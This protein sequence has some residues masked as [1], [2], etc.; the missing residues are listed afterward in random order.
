MRSLPFDSFAP[1]VGVPLMVASP[2]HDD[3]DALRD[4]CGQWQWGLYRARSCHAA[5]RLVRQRR[6]SVVLCDRDL[7]GGGWRAVVQGLKE[8][9]HLTRLIVSSRFADHRLWMDVLELGGYDVLNS[10]F[11]ANEVAR[12][13]FLAWYALRHERSREL[14]IP[15]VVA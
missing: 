15:A 13:V 2:F 3:H 1:D 6:I 12:V 10:P 11:D 8:V 14:A 7:P 5:L 4:M 9:P